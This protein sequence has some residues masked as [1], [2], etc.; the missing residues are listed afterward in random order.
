MALTEVSLKQPASPEQPAQKNTTDKKP[1]DGGVEVETAP[2]ADA[3]KPED[4][5]KPA[6]D[7]KLSVGRR[8][9]SKVKRFF[10]HPFWAHPLVAG[11]LIGGA[12]TQYYTYKQKEAEFQ[13]S[14]QQI[15]LT[16]QQSFSDE[17]NKIR[18]QKIGEVWEQIDKNEVTLDDLLAEANESPGSTSNNFAKIKSIVDEDVATVHKNRFWLGDYLYGELQRYLSV[19]E[20]IVEGMLLG[21]PGIDLSEPLK[22]RNQ[23]KLD[24]NRVRNL[25]LKG[26]PELLVQPTPVSR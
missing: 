21:K 7:Q 25:L 2:Q 10:S 18:I 15:E 5:A 9:F 16:R 4:A 19:N 8:F 11:V 6:E 13:R 14:S 23:A 22:R 24:I 12:V 3:A 20:E 17:M 26:E 1:E